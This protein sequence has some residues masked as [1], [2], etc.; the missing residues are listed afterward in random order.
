MLAERG[1]AKKSYACVSRKNTRSW[2]RYKNGNE[3]GEEECKNLPEEFF[4]VNLMV[5]KNGVKRRE[6]VGSMGLSALSIWLP[7]M[8]KTLQISMSRMRG[9]LSRTLKIIMESYI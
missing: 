2:S 1:S 9:H 4:S 8:N 3:E 7:R 5:E 6:G